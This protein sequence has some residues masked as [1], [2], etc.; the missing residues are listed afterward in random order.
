MT[1]VIVYHI[2]NHESDSEAYIYLYE[3]NCGHTPHEPYEEFD[4]LRE[5]LK[6]NKHAMI[7]RF[8][9]EIF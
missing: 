4:N 1:R 2:E 9:G 7:L 3:D 6:Y 8:P 5:A